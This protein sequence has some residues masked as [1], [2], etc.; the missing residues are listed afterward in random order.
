MNKRSYEKINLLSTW[1]V[2]QVESDLKPS[3]FQVNL[4]LNTQDK[5]PKVFLKFNS[6]KM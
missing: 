5:K 3:Q 4:A 2:F 1:T 6:P